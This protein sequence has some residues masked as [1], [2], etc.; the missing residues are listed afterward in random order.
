MV[1]CKLERSIGREN[2]QRHKFIYICDDIGHG[3]LT[4]FLVHGRNCTILL[5]FRNDCFKNDTYNGKGIDCLIYEG[6]IQLYV[7]TLIL[8]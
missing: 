8:H 5:I 1:Q 7:V 4:V 2:R 6:L 3:Y